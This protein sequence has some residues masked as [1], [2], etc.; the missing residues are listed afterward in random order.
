[1]GAQRGGRPGVEAGGGG[2]RPVVTD[3]VV[4]ASSGKVLEDP[5]FSTSNGSLIQ[6]YPLNLGAN[7]RWVFVPLAGGNDLIVNASSGEVLDDPS[8]STSN[9]TP[10]H[11]YQLNGGTNQQWKIVGQADGNRWCTTRTAARCLPTHLSTTNGT[12]HPAIPAQR[13]PQPA[14]EISPFANPAGITAYSPAPAGT[15]LF[16]SGGPSYLDV[17]RT[18]VTVG[19]CWLEASLAE[20]AARDPQD[21]LNMFTYDGTT[22]DNGDMV[23]LYTVRFFN[24]SGPQFTLRWTL[25][26][27]PAAIT[28]T[29]FTT[30]WVPGPVGRLGRE[31]LRGGQRPRLRDHR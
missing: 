18:T 25:N 26:S 8:F 4:N 16:K 21:I 23:G 1:M 15:P 5:W 2:Y 6:Q 10:I 11:Q 27:P 9:G 14:M 20:V 19:D 17:K 30:T 12:P 22:V 7:Q 31:G 3:Y 13:R 29:M 24:T 28:M